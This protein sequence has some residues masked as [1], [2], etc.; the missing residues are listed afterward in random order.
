GSPGDRYEVGGG[1][2]TH[3]PGPRRVPRPPPAFFRSRIRR[4]SMTLSPLARRRIAI[5]RAS[6]RGYWSLWI[7]LALFGLSLCA[8]VIANDQPLVVRYDGRW[9]FPVLVSYPETA[10]GGVLPT[11]AVYRE[12]EVRR[13]LEAQGWVAC[14]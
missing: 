2:R 3:P 4:T 1:R 6:R 14:A 5:F 10:F 9:Y 11:A 13:L 8:E 12:P 7:F